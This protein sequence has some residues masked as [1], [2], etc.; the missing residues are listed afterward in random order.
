MIRVV[1]RGSHSGVG[2]KLAQLLDRLFAELVAVMGVVE[3]EF[4]TV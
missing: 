2:Q 4:V 1:E 3:E